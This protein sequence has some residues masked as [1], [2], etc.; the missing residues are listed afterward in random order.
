[1]D[2]GGRRGERGCA[3]LVKDEALPLARA[4]AHGDDPDGPL[5]ELQ[6]GHGLRVHLEPAALVAIKKIE[7]EMKQD[8]YDQ[9]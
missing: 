8:E 3:N 1:M 4:A 9:L 5:D 7:L 2:S 6:R